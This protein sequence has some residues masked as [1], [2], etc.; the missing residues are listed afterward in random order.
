MCLMKIVCGI[1]HVGCKG[2]K[3]AGSTDLK[4]MWTF[5]YSG[6]GTVN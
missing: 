2:L 6:A 5:H 4:M 3:K 1:I